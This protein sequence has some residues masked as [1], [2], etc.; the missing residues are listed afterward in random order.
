LLATIPDVAE[1][2]INESDSITAKGMAHFGTMASL[3]K[4]DLDAMTN[5]GEEGLA[6]LRRCRSLEEILLNNFGGVTDKGVGYLVAVPKLRKLHIHGAKLTEL[7]IEH[8]RNMKSLTHLKI[9]YAGLTPEM[10]ESLRKLP[11][12]VVEVDAQR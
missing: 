3:R 11:G 7:S 9:G 8:F 4:L 5:V 2:S 10:T 1:V 6:A 12:V